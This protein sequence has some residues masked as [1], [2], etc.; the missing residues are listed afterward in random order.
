MEASCSS[1][2]IIESKKSFDD[3]KTLT[4]DKRLLGIIPINLKLLRA[5]EK[6]DTRC[7]ELV[8]K[9]DERY[10]DLADRFVYKDGKPIWSDHVGRRYVLTLQ[11]MYEAVYSSGSN[12]FCSGNNKYINILCFDHRDLK[13]YVNVVDLF[14]TIFDRN[15]TELRYV[16]RKRTYAREIR[17]IDSFFL[18]YTKDF[19]TDELITRYKLQGDDAVRYNNK[20]KISKLYVCFD[21]IVDFVNDFINSVNEDFRA[22]L[23]FK[24]DAFIK[25]MLN[26]REY[27]NIDRLKKA[28]KQGYSDHLEIALRSFNFGD[29]KS[30]GSL[31]FERL[32]F[33]HGDRTTDMIFKDMVSF[34][35]QYGEKIKIS[36]YIIDHLTR[37]L[38]IVKS[39][40]PPEMVEC[41]SISFDKCDDE[42]DSKKQRTE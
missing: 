34:Y 33:F 27:I 19:I 14:E 7:A 15:L 37:L 5:D 10:A 18:Q 1:N 8:Y 17:D 30:A 39:K 42:S 38:E 11:F 31:Q 24:S 23:R 35:E 21:D 29:H 20:D 2:V 41:N 3:Y 4:C 12:A 16:Q 26:I 36:G 9:S 6:N 28:C 25:S 40:T 13:V 32:D 22:N